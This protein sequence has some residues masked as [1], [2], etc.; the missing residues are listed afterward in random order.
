MKT[1]IV[2][3]NKN[4]EINPSKFIKP[5]GNRG[6]NKPNKGGFWTSSITD[7]NKSGWIN[8]AESNEFY[9]DWSELKILKVEIKNDARILFINSQEDY[10]KALEKYGRPADRLSNPLAFFEGNTQILDF[11]KLT[12]DYDAL[13]LT[14]DGLWTNYNT[15]YGWDCESTVWFNIECFESIVEM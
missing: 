3:I 4:E 15:F 12:E 14:E 2:V 11:D 13:S 7:D 8:F 6:N 5:E 9:N 10:D 1:Q